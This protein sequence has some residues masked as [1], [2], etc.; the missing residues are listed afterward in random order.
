MTNSPLRLLT[1]PPSDAFA[2]PLEPAANDTHAPVH[3]CGCGR[4]YD[5]ARWCALPLVGVQVYA[6]AGERQVLRLC[7]CGS[8]R[9]R[10]WCIR[11]N[12]EIP[13]EADGCVTPGCVS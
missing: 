8:T 12:A 2:E 1:R 5:A 9:A 7:A 11:C 10:A 3:T 13:S 6:V 4:A